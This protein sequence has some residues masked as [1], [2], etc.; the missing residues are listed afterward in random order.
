MALPSINAEDTSGS[1]A[2]GSPLKR[3]QQGTLEENGH[4]ILLSTDR[5]SQSLE[6][7]LGQV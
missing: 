1:M 5:F 2:L 6:A 7:V 4:N 3:K